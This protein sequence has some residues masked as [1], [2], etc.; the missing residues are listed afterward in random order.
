MPDEGN[1]ILKYNQGEKSL[2]A[3]AIIYADLECLLKKMHSCQKNLENFYTE[4]K[5]SI[6]LL[7][8]HCL[9]LVHLMQQKVSLIVTEIKIA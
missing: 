5:L 4:K 7:D 1:K 9:Q 6:R 3:Q 8:I 2:K